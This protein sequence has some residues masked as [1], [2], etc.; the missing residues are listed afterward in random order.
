VS[1]VLG[2]GWCVE[3]TSG[4]LYPMLYVGVACRSG[5]FDWSGH[6]MIEIALEIMSGLLGLAGMVGY[7]VCGCVPG[8]ENTIKPWQVWTLPPCIFVC[9]ATAMEMPG[10]RL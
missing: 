6:L 7:V 8:Y 2:L 10:F 4:A 1:W 9:M 5:Q 3:L